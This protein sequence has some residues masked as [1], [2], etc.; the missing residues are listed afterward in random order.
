MKKVLMVLV[1]LG[2][3]GCVQVDKYSEVVKMPAPPGLAGYWQ[4]QGPQNKLVSP[5]AIAS[6]I[7]TPQG[8]TLDCRQ[9]QRV[10]ALPG[11]LMA[12]GAREYNVTVK[13]EVYALERDADTLKYAGMTLERV[14]RPTAECAAWLEKHPLQAAATNSSAAGGAA[15][16]GTDGPPAQN[17]PE[18]KPV[19]TQGP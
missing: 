5:Q 17:S 3:S 9:W 13:R 6:L 18:R 11:K 15:V 2:L 16:V 10:I 14:A 1:L 4:T 8:D 19:A 7:V 12:R